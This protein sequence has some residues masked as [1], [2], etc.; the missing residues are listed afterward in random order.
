MADDRR[1]LLERLQMLEQQSARFQDELRKLRAELERRNV[2]AEA[3]P[4]TAAEP[5]PGEIQIEEPE[6]P[7]AAVRAPSDTFAADERRQKYIDLE[8]W[9]GGRG[10]LLLGVLALVLAVGFFVNYAID[11]GW[12]GPT[13][14]VLLGG[15]VGVATIVAG[16]RIRAAGYRTYGLWLAAGGFAAVYLSIWAAQALYGLVPPG[17]GFAA[18]VAAVGAAAGM[19]LLRSSEA[20]VALAGFG[21]YLAPLLLKVEVG[22]GLFGLVYLASLSGTGLA[23]ARYQSWRFLAAVGI[24]GGSLMTL[25]AG[26]ANPHFFGVYLVALLAVAL[27]VARRRL[28]PDIALLA[29]VTVWVT[30]GGGTHRWAIEGLTLAGYAGALWLT[31][32]VGT[33]GAGGWVDE[34]LRARLDSGS[35]DARR[36]ASSIEIAGLLVLPPALFYFFAW[37][38]LGESRFSEWRETASLLLGLILGASYLL[39]ARFAGAVRGAR[40]AWISWLGFA[41]ILFAPVVQW[42]GLSLARGWLFEG[43]A[44]AAVGLGLRTPQARAAGLLALVLAVLAYADSAAGRPDL[45]AAFVSGWALTGLGVIIALAMWSLA[46][47]LAQ[48]KTSWEEEIREVTVVAAVALFFIWGTLEISRFYDL[49]QLGALAADQLGWRLARDLSISG[50]WMAYAVA[51]LSAGFALTRVPLRW[52]GLVMALIAAGKVLLYDLSNL[53]QLYRIVSFSLLA[54]VLLSLSFGYQKLRRQREAE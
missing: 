28:W 45:D 43:I 29:V 15:V 27:L 7:E 16:E 44:L 18:M 35:T 31:C 46:P 23:V 17:I 40:E 8:F 41:L 51:L 19:G 53:S 48:G 36:K 1:R 5:E 2:A 21:G 49:R 9:L 52:A 47:R 42:S 10:L 26:G 4:V 6:P 37:V 22:A 30:L 50:F 32:L 34:G 3:E 38:G 11:R 12:I 20:F 39:L 54:V 25:A 24:V 13:V 33:A 14:R